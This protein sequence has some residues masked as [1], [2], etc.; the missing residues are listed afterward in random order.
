MI[1]FRRRSHWLPIALAS[2]ATGCADTPQPAASTAPVAATLP[3][4]AAD[5]H[6]RYDGAE[7]PQQW[8]S[9]SPKFATC[10]EG[11]SQS[12]ID[13]AIQGTTAGDPIKMSF[14][15][16]QL[17]IAHNA[18]VSDGINN[19]HTIQINYAGGD[20][21]TIGPESYALVQFHFHNQSEHSV[22]G[23]RYPMEMHLVHK[24]ASG[25]LAVI[26]VFIE[27][28]ER[29][30]AFEPLWANLPPAPGAEMH[31]PSVTIDVD[32][33]LPAVRTSYRY[34]G[35][36][37]TPPCS[38]GVRWIVMTTP[39]HLSGDQIRAFTAVIHDNNRPTQPLNGR[40][41]V[42]DAVASR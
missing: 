30:P 31:V 36:L 27:E 3:A 35:S 19:G 32:D 42:T 7:G 24:A 26:G 8:G 2:L 17:R 11:R 14:P 41:L 28:G 20:T 4:P 1:R 33:L 6:W 37:T 23:K 21:L 38:E 12:P 22:G 9:L 13:I 29:N 25:K 5:P 10:A 15:P 34:D 18:H 40:Q 39:I 16:A